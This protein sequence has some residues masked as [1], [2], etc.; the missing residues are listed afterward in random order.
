MSESNSEGRIDIKFIKTEHG[1]DKEKILITPDMYLTGRLYASQDWA[2]RA[3][4][5]KARAF[6]QGI[7]PDY[8][9]PDRSEAYTFHV[10]ADQE[11]RVLI[12]NGHHRTAEGLL[13]GRPYGLEVGAYLGVL[14]QELLDNPQLA[15]QKLAVLGIQGVFPFK[16]FMQKF[17]DVRIDSVK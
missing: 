6:T 3:D 10:E 8:K 9:S 14:S 4:V 7:I 16:K 15:M 5:E 17:I 2:K 13:E 12:G 1:V 11:I